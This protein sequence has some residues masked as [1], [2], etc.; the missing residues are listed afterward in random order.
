MFLPSIGVFTN[1]LL[2]IL[3]HIL[4]LSLFPF[5]CAGYIACR[6]LCLIVTCDDLS[7]VCLLPTLTHLPRDSPSIFLYFLS[8]VCQPSYFICFSSG[9]PTPSIVCS[10]LLPDFQTGWPTPSNIFPHFC[11]LA[12]SAGSPSTYDTVSG[13]IV[14]FGAF[15]HFFT[16]FILVVLKF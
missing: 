6:V 5:W 13:I 7:P 4:L 16:S 10:P 1:I 12:V 9:W 3:V 14:I 2:S 8:A 15:A 11:V